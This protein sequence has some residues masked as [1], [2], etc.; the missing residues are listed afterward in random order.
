MG[1]H[2]LNEKLDEKYGRNY[3]EG[4]LVYL[5][6][7]HQPKKPSG[8]PTAQ[9]T[10]EGDYN[11]QP[12]LDPMGLGNMSENE[13]PISQTIKDMFNNPTNT[14][15]PILNSQSVIKGLGSAGESLGRGALAAI[16]GVFGD[17]EKLGREGI[18]YIGSGKNSNNAMQ[19]D[20][21]GNPIMSTSYGP[22]SKLVS[23][24][25]Y[26]PATEDYLKMMPR[27][28]KKFGDETANNF[29]E[30]LGGFL[31]PPL[32]SPA[33]KGAKILGEHAAEK[34]LSG[35]PWVKG[36][37]FLNP[38]VLGA[39]KPK[40]G[41]TPLNLG[42]TLPLE[43]QGEMGKYLFES[44]ITDPMAIFDKRLRYHF[45]DDYVRNEKLRTA[46]KE[47]LQRKIEEN[48]N[49]IAYSDLNGKAMNDLVRQAAQE[50]TEAAEHARLNGGDPNVKKL[51][52]P[53]EIEASAKHYNEWLQGPMKKYITKEMGS[54]LE[55]D[56]LLKVMNESSIPE[57]TLFNTREP[58]SS[59]KKFVTDYAT[60]RRKKFAEEYSGGY[61]WNRTPELEEMVKNSVIGKQTA[62]TPIGQ[63]YEDLIDKSFYPGGNYN[64]P[65]EDFPGMSFVKETDVINDFLSRPEENLGFHKIQDRILND[66]LEGKLNPSKLAT[67][68]PANVV[69]DMIKEKVAAIK[70]LQKSKEAYHGWRQANHNSDALPSDMRFTDA[71]GNPTGAK[72]VIFDSKLANENP[73][74][75]TR[76]LAQE[77]KDLNHCVGACGMDNGNYIPMV[78]P[79]T[80]IANKVDSS[81][82][83]RYLEQMKRGEI[84]VASLRGPNGES[85]V[86]FE[87]NPIKKLNTNESKIR[88]INQDGQIK[89]EVTYGWSAPNKKDYFDTLDAA[90][91]HVSKLA[92]VP[93]QFKVSQLK[94]KNNKHV[95]DDVY[96]NDA[97]NWLNYKHQTGELSNLPFRDIQNLPGVYD[98]GNMDNV[99]DFQFSQDPK[100]NR[101]DKLYD[102][103]IRN[104]LKENPQ[105]SR[106]YSDGKLFSFEILPELGRFL[107]AD[108][109]IN[110]LAPK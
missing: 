23:P 17:F 33:A 31:T 58:D 107:T 37:E 46:Y 48:A 98:F 85:K 106:D 30:G 93:Q 62:T 44:Q 73:D 14:L 64:F 1:A 94:G 43:K 36:A 88:P 71:E 7:G 105:L 5:A 97:K 95:L 108:D 69:Q 28:S 4:G 11:Y 90:E 12:E 52:S 102:Q 87:L 92:T 24:N 10:L 8:S 74:L 32:I 38:T 45:G 83:P 59:H 27:Y 78:E 109:I 16:P 61:E 79:H 82:G 47:H 21:L 3:A 66:L 49:G 39:V 81:H 65:K 42:S 25:S 99:R 63:Y 34:M 9:V 13:V 15:S 101:A 86:T 72:L 67:R 20:E 41:N 84:S 50:F 2:Y 76:N 70:A 75:V 89:Y 54:G 55:T 103:A 26:L 68:T 100:V 77:T 60:E 91:A 22:S 110:K 56:P 104:K 57:H 19:Y 18:N 96:I 6:G 53:S 40:G 35:E 29:L 51:Y 80:G